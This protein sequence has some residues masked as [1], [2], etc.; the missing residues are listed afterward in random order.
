MS[1]FRFSGGRTAL[2]TLAYLGYPKLVEA[3]RRYASPCSLNIE[4]GIGHLYYLRSAPTFFFHSSYL[5]F[6]C[7]DQLCQSLAP[8]HSRYNFSAL[9]L[10]NHSTQSP[11]IA[12]KA[13]TVLLAFVAVASANLIP[14]ADSSVSSPATTTSASLSPTATCLAA[15]SPGDVTCEAACVG[16]AHPNSSQASETNDCA[17][18]CPKGDGSTAASDA[19][20]QCL[21]AC[22]ASNFPTTQTV[23]PVGVTGTV[24]S[25]A[26]S[27]TGTGAAA[28]GKDE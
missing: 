19:Y 24:T 10:S 17:A 4:H 21:A 25:N 22:I 5:Y 3:R 18:Q 12:M 23:G 16:A 2:H 26:A 27:A 15:C 1:I 28:S 6:H 11:N 9:F 13:A 7:K 14:R 8:Y 20:A